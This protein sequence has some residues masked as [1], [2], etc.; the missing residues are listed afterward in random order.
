MISIPVSDRSHARIRR[1]SLWLC[2]LGY[3]ALALGFAWA[4]LSGHRNAE[5]ILKDAVTVQAPVQLDRIDEHRRKGRVSHEYQFQ[6]RFNV[7]GVAHT[8]TFATS[9]DSAAPYLEEGALVRV[10]YSRAQPARFDRLE[11]LQ[12]QQR[13]GAVLGR[14]SVGILLLGVLAFVVYLL[15]TRK[16][17]VPRAPAAVPA[18]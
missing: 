6:Y 18:A 2:T 16:L 12:S 1:F 13:L 17:F 9:E 5:A 15:L 4:A 3:A 11:R 14:L 10:A 8:G 7:D